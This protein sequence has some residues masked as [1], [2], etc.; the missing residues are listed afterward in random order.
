MIA[1]LSRIRRSVLT[2]A[3]PV[4]LSSL[5]QRAEGMLT[6]ILVGGLGTNALASVGLSQLLIFIATTLLAGLSVS[7]T[8]VVAQLWGARRRADAREA[9]VHLLGIGIG[10]A[11][12]LALVGAVVAP[13]L[14]QALGADPDVIALATPYVR[15]MFAILPVTIGLQVLA[16]ILQGTGDTRT[17][18]VALI[19]VNL[20]YL[21]LA[22][23]LI[24]GLGG[25]PT[26]G[27]SGAAFAVATAESLGL[28]LLLWRARS[29]LC[30]PTHLRWDLIGSA[31][32]VGAP[33]SGERMLQQA[34]ILLYTKLV[35]SYGT[36]AYAAHQVGLSIEAL[37]FLPGHGFAIA[38]ASMV[39]QSIGAGKYQ[40]A[41]M[42]NWE[43]NRQA[44]W[45]MTAMGLVFYFA[46]TP[47][48]RLYTQDPGVIE[49]GA[50][51]LRIVA[52]IQIPLALTMV[53]AGSL[54]GAGDT[55]FI[56]GVTFVGMWGIR[57]PAAY[58][59]AWFVPG[60]VLAVWWGMVIDWTLRMFL[61][62]WRYRSGRWRNIRVLQDASSK[63]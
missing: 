46:P 23:P 34:G 59:A 10:A 56:M 45:M 43:A 62:L 37:S 42:E 61:M 27:I 31:W 4:T 29:L 44:L 9:A 50:S 36:V 25:L 11:A 15:L 14:M 18:A 53:L 32:T 16:A 21:A 38:A 47:L 60:T 49:L 52:L 39:G 55:R 13:L 63:H 58:L 17:P 3:L 54:R 41:T 19:L 8:V 7:G 40:R 57:L 22:Y 30:C 20:L 1:R 6:L 5:L 51:F 28:A 12:L 35:I 48:L 24:Y 33:A 2:L 26:F